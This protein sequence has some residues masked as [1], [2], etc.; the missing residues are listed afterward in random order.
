MAKEKPITVSSLESRINQ[1][2][3][4]GQMGA[5]ESAEKFADSSKGAVRALGKSPK[6]VLADRRKQAAEK[7]TARDVTIGPAGLSRD[8]MLRQESDTKLQDIFA[9]P[10]GQEDLPFGRTDELTEKLKAAK[11]RRT[12]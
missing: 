3:P 8:R 7:A 1:R 10:L 2:A 6:N 9:N 11:A 4:R 12:K 5:F